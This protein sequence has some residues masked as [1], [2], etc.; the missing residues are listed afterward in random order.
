[1]VHGRFLVDW[2]YYVAITK[3]KDVPF[4]KIPIIIN[5]LMN[6]FLFLFDFRH[7]VDAAKWQGI[8]GGAA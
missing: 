8:A 4:F 1:M 5:I 6:L 3:A 2:N 7:K